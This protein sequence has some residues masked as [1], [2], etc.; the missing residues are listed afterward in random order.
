MEGQFV[1][2][3][4]SNYQYYFN[5]LARNRQVILTSQSY[6]TKEACKNGIRAIMSNSQKESQ[7]V[8]RTSLK[9]NP[10]FVIIGQNGQVLG[11][12]EMY[13]SNQAMENGV[14]AV[15]RYAPRAEIVDKTI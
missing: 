13:N 15:K 5:L 12:S 14:D 11:K 8:R 7:F 3:H 4:N 2:K 9:M 1:I 10:Y 6:S